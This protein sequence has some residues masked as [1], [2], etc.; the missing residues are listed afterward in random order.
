MLTQQVAI[1]SGTP[2][3][4]PSQLA[5]VAA[6]VQIQVN[7]DVTPIWGISAIITPFPTLDD[8]PSGYYFIWITDNLPGVE[9]YHQDEY[10]QPYA[11]VKYG[12]K[13][14]VTVSHECIEMLI[15]PHGN[16]LVATSSP[17]AGQGRI[18][19]LVEVCDPSEAFSYNVNGIPVCD[20]YTPHYFDDVSSPATRYSF[21]G[22]IT[23]PKQVLPG[24]YVSWYEPVTNKLW[25]Q[26]N[27][28]GTLTLRSFDNQKPP[29]QSLRAFI[30]SQ[31][32]ET[33]TFNDAVTKKPVTFVSGL[34]EPAPKKPA[35][36]SL[37]GAL[38]AAPE[39]FSFSEAHEQEKIASKLIADRI[40][41]RL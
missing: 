14:P 12:P 36:R 40:R 18:N 16:R 6:A 3:I 29:T 27:V 23:Q 10:G 25:Q 11:F 19:M 30:D 38:K 28:N 4:T 7:R 39:V 1:V 22:V 32:Q 8:I 20:F 9:G 26:F 33:V 17:A 31:T 2:N 13:W 34:A 15:D 35:T 37:K 21:M 24:G 41:L 5:Q